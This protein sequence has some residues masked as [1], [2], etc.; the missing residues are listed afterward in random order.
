MRKKRARCLDKYLCFFS[1]SSSVRLKEIDSILSNQC[2]YKILNVDSK[3]NREA[4]K[5]SYQQLA[6]KYH[7]DYA[8]NNEELEKFTKAFTK[9]NTSYKVLYNISKR[10]KYDMA[11]K[12]TE[13]KFK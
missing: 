1:S 8:K 2:F 4:I 11:K 7:P 6:M 9:I 3:I 5:K 13:R 10:Q 12:Y